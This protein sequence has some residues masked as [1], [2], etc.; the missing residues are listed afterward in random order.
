MDSVFFWPRIWLEMDK[1]KKAEIDSEWSTAD[2]FL[3]FSAVS[4]VGGVL[5][6]LE[7]AAASLGVGT[8]TVPTGSAA[9]AVPGGLAWLAA[10]YAFYRVSL[11][12]HRQNGEVFKSIFDLYRSKVLKPMA[13]LP[14]EEQLWDATWNY[15]QYLRFVC[16]NCG[17]T[18]AKRR[19]QCASCNF[20]LRETIRKA[21]ASGKLP[22][23]P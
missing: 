13:P 9:W 14:Q 4:F 1:D 22:L 18:N 3:M 11:P 2:G 15:L 7:A 20:D 8:Q 12:F 16:P 10:G 6:I 21:Q 17:N 19:E 5:W 23:R